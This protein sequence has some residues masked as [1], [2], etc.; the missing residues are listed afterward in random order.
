M[1]FTNHTTGKL[2]GQYTSTLD[3][4]IS[5]DSCFF[6]FQ[7]HSKIKPTTRNNLYRWHLSVNTLNKFL[8]YLVIIRHIFILFV[9]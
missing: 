2:C 6:L 9:P 7:N 3:A 1:V 4:F 8:P 5:N